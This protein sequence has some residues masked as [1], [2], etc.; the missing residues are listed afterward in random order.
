M[1]CLDTST[2]PAESTQLTQLRQEVGDLVLKTC[3]DFINDP[4]NRF[5]LSTEYERL[6]GLLTR[7]HPSRSL[8]LCFFSQGFR[9]LITRGHDLVAN[10]D[11]SH[12]WE[13]VDAIDF[14][15]D[16]IPGCWPYTQESDSYRYLAW[17]REHALALTS[18]VH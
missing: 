4:I 15:N 11:S 13:L 1:N 12:H 5:I 8:Q 7:P 6:L 17:S 10:F 18:T 14:F 2:Q 3:I 9:A 16:S